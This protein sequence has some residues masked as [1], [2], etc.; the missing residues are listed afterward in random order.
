VPRAENQRPA[1]I[2]AKHRLFRV[3]DQVQEDLLDLMRVRE[4]ER[5]P[6]GQRLEDVDV[7]QALFVRAERNRLADDLIQIDHGTRGVP[8]PREREEIA[9]DLR[10]AFGFAEDRVQ[11]APRRF[12]ELALRQPLGP[13]QDRREG[14][15]QLVRDA[16]DR[17]AQCRQLLR[18][19]QLMVE[20]ARLIL[21]ALAFRDV[22]HQRLDPQP[23]RLV[24]LG[25]RGDLDPDRDAVLAPQAHD[26]IG[27]GAVAL[28]AF[29]EAGARLRIDEAFGRKRQ[30]VVLRRFHR[31]AEDQLEVGIGRHGLIF[32]TTDRADVHAF[33]DRLEEPR[34]RQASVRELRRHLPRVTGGVGVIVGNEDRYLASMAARMSAIPAP[35]EC[36]C[37]ASRA[38]SRQTAQP[39]PCGSHAVGRPRASRD[40]T[41]QSSLC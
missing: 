21:Q 4:H 23:A 29:D 28:Q 16:R 24:A 10:R 31:E 9:D 33:V 27:D 3:D 15:V 12:V 41:K 11:A 25:V 8:L 32:G 22:A 38:T 13:R 6:R 37:I 7:A 39:T 35:A 19:E 2:G 34:E 1:A 14:V 20:I 17:L 40:A 36:I 26:V 18:L 30:Q 5:Q